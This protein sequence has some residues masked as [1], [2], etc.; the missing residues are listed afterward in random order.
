MHSQTITLIGL[1]G[2]GGAVARSLPLTLAWM[3]VTGNHF[4]IN[5][6]D[7]DTFEPHNAVRQS[8][9]WAGPK[10]K[11]VAE[12]M[13]DNYQATAKNE[14]P[15]ISFHPFVEY[16][17]PSNV[18]AH[19]VSG[20]IVLLAVDDHYPRRV[21]S[22]FASGL[23]DIVVISGSNNELT[24][25]TIQLY[26]RS[27]GRDT[28]LPLNNQFHPEIATAEHRAQVARGC[29]IRFGSSESKQ[30]FVVNNRVA[31]TMLE[32]LYLTFTTPNANAAN[33]P[34]EVRLDVKTLTQRPVMLR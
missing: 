3:S 29:G 32:L 5:L 14:L 15:P 7:G 11:V 16:V 30:L 4:V 2:V 31:A 34:D 1:G 17:K 28:T 22:E 10:A 12:T 18:A 8:F 6:V 20:D 9:R 33:L 27:N 19:I 25:G 13:R 21:V 26:A 24:E 23:T